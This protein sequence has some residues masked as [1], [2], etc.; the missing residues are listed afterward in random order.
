MRIG[1]GYIMLRR[2][3]K[4]YINKTQVGE[5]YITSIPTVVD[6]KCNE[7]IVGKAEL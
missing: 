7:V 4:I 3:M 2:T 1:E 5:L 6:V